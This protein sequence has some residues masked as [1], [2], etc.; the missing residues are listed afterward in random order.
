MNIPTLYVGTKVIRAT[1]M[2][3]CEYNQYRNWATPAN[4]NPNDKGFLV[5]YCDGGAPND[6]RHKGYISWSPEDVF[7]KSYLFM[8]TLGTAQE[9]NETYIKLLAE[10]VQLVARIEELTE[11]LGEEGL[12]LEERRLLSRHRLQL[13]STKDVVLQRLKRFYSEQA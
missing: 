1:P 10:H 11:N 7:E 8:G 3:R 12:P 5:E 9:C 13:Q 4:E 6:P 2:T